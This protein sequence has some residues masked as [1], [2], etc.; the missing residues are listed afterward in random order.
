MARNAE[1]A[2][3]LVKTLEDRPE[4]EDVF[5][6]QIGEGTTDVSLPVPDDLPARG[7]DARRPTR[8]PAVARADAAEAGP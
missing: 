2:V 5:L 3:P 4:F 8:G 6:V 7:P 1:D